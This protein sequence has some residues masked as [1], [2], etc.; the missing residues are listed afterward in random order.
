MFVNI[1]KYKLTFDALSGWFESTIANTGWVLLDTCTTGSSDR[2]H[3]HIR[4]LKQLFMALHQAH[5][6]YKSHDKLYD[7]VIML[8]KVKLMLK[9]LDHMSNYKSTKSTNLI[10]GAFYSKIPDY[11]ITYMGLYKWY[12]HMIDKFGWILLAY[13]EKHKEKLEWYVKALKYLH[14]YLLQSSQIYK[15]HDKL[16]D[17]SVMN[18]K[19]EHLIKMTQHISLYK[20]DHMHGGRKKSKN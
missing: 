19:I 8:H 17:I 7:I 15:D 20:V 11:D 10:G 1:P 16:F 6:S 9:I 12:T 18:K 4:K 14:N 3:Y 13:C 2:L 5:E